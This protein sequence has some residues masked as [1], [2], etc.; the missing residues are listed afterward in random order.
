MHLSSVLRFDTNHHASD[1]VLEAT[2][3]LRRVEAKVVVEQNEQRW[4]IDE[5]LRNASQHSG[6][7]AASKVRG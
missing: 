1:V 5:Q 4:T 6:H 2:G 7:F 3:S